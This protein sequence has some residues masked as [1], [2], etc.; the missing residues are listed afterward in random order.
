VNQ[1]P[2]YLEGFS[3]E[4]QIPTIILQIDLA[5]ITIIVIASTTTTTIAIPAMDTIEIISLK[6]SLQSIRFG[7]S[8]CV[9]MEPA[10][11]MSIHDHSFSLADGSTFVVLGSIMTCEF[12]FSLS[13]LRESQ[14]LQNSNIVEF[15]SLL[16][17]DDKTRQHVYYQV[18]RPLSPDEILLISFRQGLEPIFL[19]RQLRRS[20]LVFRRYALFYPFLV[21]NADTCFLFFSCRPSTKLLHGIWTLTSWVRL[22]SLSNNLIDDICRA[23]GYEF[24]MQNCEF[25]VSFSVS[26]LLTE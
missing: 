6:S 4:I 12:F 22:P 20:F 9:S 16:K 2:I 13:Y 25:N 26:Q 7:H 23:D 24:L 8:S 17:K 10:I 11:S 1:R 18:C 19:Q 5:F 3:L 14:V 15:F 21:Q